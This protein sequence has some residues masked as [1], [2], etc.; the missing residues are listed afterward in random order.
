MKAASTVFSSTLALSLSLTAL[1]GCSSEETPPSTT[2]GGKSGT[3]GAGTGAGT[4]GGSTVGGSGGSG[5][6][7]A[8]TTGGT[9]GTAGKTGTGGSG[10]VVS[11]CPTIDGE[12]SVSEPWQVSFIGTTCEG[13]VTE[14]SGSFAITAL[15]GD[16]YGAADSFTFVSQPFSGTEGEITAKVTADPTV[17][18][19]K[20][21]VMF[22]ADDSASSA[23]AFTFGTYTDGSQFLPRAASAMSTPVFS[24][25]FSSAE[26]S[27]KP[28]WV[29]TVMHGDQ[30][31]GFA[32]HDGDHWLQ[33]STQ[34]VT[35]GS[36][37]ILAGIAVAPNNAGDA[38]LVQVDEVTV[39]T[40]STITVDPIPQDLAPDADVSTYANAVGVPWASLKLGAANAADDF[41][42]G[43][44]AGSFTV[45]TV[46][47]DIWDESDNAGFIYQEVSGDFDLVG[48]VD[49]FE[50]YFEWAKAGLMIRASLDDD[51]ANTNL[52]FAAPGVDATTDAVNVH[53]VCQ[54]R[55]LVT[56]DPTTS[57]CVTFMAGSGYLKLSRR[58]LVITAYLSRNGSDWFA[59]E[60]DTY[61]E[62]D[63]PDTLYAGVAASN[64]QSADVDDVPGTARF[65]AV[66]ITEL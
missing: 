15:G 58:G 64:H 65:S 46:G 22:R 53:G 29:K 39:S 45:T 48:K 59:L 24:V 13:K 7:A 16:I 4:G 51:A 14:T 31:T 5:G 55:R 28:V 42:A 43:D 26:L 21:G 12:S 18:G 57:K 34:T 3:S 17:E 66:A 25:G 47:A 33:L 1:S 63:L 40:T 8:S 62:G 50:T 27:A 9:A 49:E 60:A 54:Q 36:T 52:V 35:F 11:A 44:D 56:A 23:M 38:A 6:S 41:K 20:V 61:L 30:L 37:D 10:G 32:S 19:T 2:S